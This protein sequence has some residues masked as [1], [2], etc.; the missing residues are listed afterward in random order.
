MK[1]RRQHLAE[2]D[3]MVRAVRKSWSGTGRL[4]NERDYRRQGKPPPP[5]VPPESSAWKMA[6]IMQMTPMINETKNM[7]VQNIHKLM[8]AKI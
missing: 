8:M 1:N 5:I 6:S 4:R 3:K 2:V 7:Q